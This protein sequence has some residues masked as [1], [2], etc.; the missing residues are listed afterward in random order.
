MPDGST[1]CGRCGARIDGKK[2]CPTCGKEIAEEYAYCNY[3]GV[4]VD[5]KTV[6]ECGNVFEGA[7]CFACGKPAKM[8]KPVRMKKARGESTGLVKKIFGFIGG[9]VYGANRYRRFLGRGI[10]A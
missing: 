8:E 6:C 10:C 2:S 4:R 9:G 1:Y 5:G 7:F 3:C